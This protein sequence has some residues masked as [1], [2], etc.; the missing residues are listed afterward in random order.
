[1]AEQKPVINQSRDRLVW[2]FFWLVVALSVY[3]NM[4]FASVSPA[5]R[6]A[7]GIVV[8]V[9]LGVLVVTTQKGQVAWGFFNSAK[10]ELVRVHWPS[11]QNTIQMTTR[12]I[13]M[14]AAVA[15]VLW[16]MDSLAMMCIRSISG[17]VL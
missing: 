5:I 16:L 13:L 12:V 15:L 10:N 11:K 2:A 6:S 17:L 4:H 7:V 9:L 14:V 3:L 1:M 8:A